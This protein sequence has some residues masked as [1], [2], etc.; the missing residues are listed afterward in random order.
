MTTGIESVVDAEVDSLS[1]ATVQ[2]RH[3]RL[4][5][6]E[7]GYTNLRPELGI[8]FCTRYNCR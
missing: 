8:E 4:N 2:I 6:Q 7:T 1:V 5:P 3:M